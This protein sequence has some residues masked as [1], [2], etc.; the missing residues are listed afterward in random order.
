MK[1][2]VD[3]V[4]ILNFI[5]DFLLLLS[6]SYI[7]KRNVSIKRIFFGALTGGISIFLLFLNLN[8]I[9]LFIYKV[10]IS[11]IMI[12]TTFSYKNFKYFINNFIYLYLCSVVLGGALYLIKDEISLKNKGLIFINSNL[13]LNLLI[14][15]VL[16]PIILFFYIKQLKK[17]KNNYN[18]YYSVELFYNNKRLMFNAFLD[19]GNKLKD[20]YKKR[21]IILVNTDKL[22]F[23]YEKCIL[24][25]YTTVNGEGVIKCLKVDKIII[26][27]NIVINK[28]LVGLVKEKFGI[29]GINMILNN[30]TI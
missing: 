10:V 27:K 18:N 11:I 7:L 2:Y 29:E 21:P 28:P 26:D 9:E 14:V 3:I 24:V 8:N 22:N 20:Q 25:P 12:L 30:E 4:F 19:T 13:K 17:L 1:V 16:I 6:V 23:S 15:I 5:I